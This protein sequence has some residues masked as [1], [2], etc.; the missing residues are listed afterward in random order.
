MYWLLHHAL[1]SLLDELMF[2]IMFGKNQV[3]L[4][5]ILIKVPLMRIMSGTNDFETSDCFIINCNL[6]P[7]LI[8]PVIYGYMYMGIYNTY[9]QY[10]FVFIVH[11][12][13]VNVT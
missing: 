2:S 9:T 3:Y 5:A 12:V 4:T 6:N 11:C 10:L 13:G 8:V 1:L 7:L